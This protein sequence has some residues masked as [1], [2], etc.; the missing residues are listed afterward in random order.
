MLTGKGEGYTPRRIDVPCRWGGEEFIMLFDETNE[1]G[2][3][4]AAERISA[5][6]KK[7]RFRDGNSGEEFGITVTIGMVGVKTAEVRELPR[8]TDLLAHYFELADRALYFGKRNGRDQ[9]VTYEA[10]KTDPENAPPEPKVLQT[11]RRTSRSVSETV[12]GSSPSRKY[13]Q[14]KAP[15]AVRKRLKIT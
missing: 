10:G 5:A 12:D 1:A 13:G 9:I 6:I 2:A 7:L 11:V 15:N 14:K 8:E 3:A 4:S